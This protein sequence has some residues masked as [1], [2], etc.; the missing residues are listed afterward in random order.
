[1]IRKIRLKDK[2]KEKNPKRID[3]RSFLTRAI[4][5]PLFSRRS[6]ARDRQRSRRSKTRR[7][8]SRCCCEWW[9]SCTWEVVQATLIG[10]RQSPQLPARLRCIAQ[11]R[12]S[13]AR[14]TTWKR[15]FPADRTTRAASQRAWIHRPA[16]N[17]SVCR[18]IRERETPRL[19][20]LWYKQQT[21]RQ[22]FTIIYYM[23]LITYHI[24]YISNYSI[25]VLYGF[26]VE[27][28]AARRFKVILIVWILRS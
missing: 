15:H 8:T 19:G 23:Y 26:S 11:S 7:C 16:N 24:M 25:S 3:S 13:M 21:I 28:L 2:S 27:A 4:G 20:K 22:T 17:I 6:E 9:C 5:R 12:C 14:C 10:R 18:W 1:M